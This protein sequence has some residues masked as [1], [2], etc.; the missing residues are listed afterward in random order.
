M[1]AVLE[2]LRRKT[3]APSDD[4]LRTDRVW[5]IV[6]SAAAIGTGIYA[7]VRVVFG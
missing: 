5:L 3:M 4:P 2:K 7:F 1:T 6:F